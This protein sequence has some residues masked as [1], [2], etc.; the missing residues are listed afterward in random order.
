MKKQ[1]PEW[2]ETFARNV[3]AKGLISKIYK[4]EIQLNIKKKFFL[5]GRGP[6]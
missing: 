4:E 1:P 6:K 5:M 2:E 3:S